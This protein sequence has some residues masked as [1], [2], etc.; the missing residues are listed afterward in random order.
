M[1]NQ[2]DDSVDA[3]APGE[4]GTEHRLPPLCPYMGYTVEYGRERMR[5]PVSWV[6]V[7]V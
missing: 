1:S 7:Y 3:I 6:T 2:S 5:L 4:N